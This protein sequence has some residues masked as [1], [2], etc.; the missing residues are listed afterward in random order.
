MARRGLVPSTATAALLLC[1]RAL[2]MEKE[3]PGK[4]KC[5]RWALRASVGELKAAF[6]RVVACLGRAEATRGHGD[7]HAARGV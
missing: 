4:R 1:L 7:L 6:G 2:R 3:E 5:R